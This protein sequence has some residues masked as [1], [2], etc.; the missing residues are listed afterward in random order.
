MQPDEKIGRKKLKTCLNPLVI[1]DHPDGIVSIYSGRIGNA[2]VNVDSAICLGEKQRQKFE[3]SLPK[4]FYI[5]LKK[6]VV[7]LSDDKK[8]MLVQQRLS[9]HVPYS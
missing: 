9:T 1:D 8:H 4:G 6:E 2:K 5:P 3:E 7:P